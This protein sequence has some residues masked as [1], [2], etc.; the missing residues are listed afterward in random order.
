M[1]VGCAMNATGVL[2]RSGV[3]YRLVENVTFRAEVST[4][5]GV[6]V[7][8]EFGNASVP[9][10]NIHIMCRGFGGRGHFF[11]VTPEG[12]RHNDYGF[13]KAIFVMTIRRFGYLHRFA[14]VSYSAS[15]ACYGDEIELILRIPLLNKVFGVVRGPR[16]S[17]EKLL[18]LSWARIDVNGTEVTMSLDGYYWLF[19]LDGMGTVTCSIPFYY[20]KSS[21]LTI[22]GGGEIEV[23]FDLSRAPL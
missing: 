21:T 17:D 10:S 23:N 8:S 2:M 14:E 18:A 4:G 5:G 7:G 6:L 22:S 12:V 13:G 3:F 9:Q 15:L 16:A 19:M 1:L 20:N 11:F